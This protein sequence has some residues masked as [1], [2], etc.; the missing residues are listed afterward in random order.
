M[1]NEAG[2][3][4]VPED[5]PRGWRRFL[6]ATNHRDIG[7]MF[8]LFALFA[9]L[10]GGALAYSM[11]AELAAP[12]LTHFSDA[13]DYAVYAT[14]HGLIM[15]FFS[16]LPAAFG[17]AIW[18]VPLM[19]GAPALAFPRIGNLAFWLLPFAFGLF[20]FSFSVP[21]DA[22]GLG[23][24]TGWQMIAPLSSYG[25]PG[26]G[27]DLVMAALFLA[28][29][30]MVLAAITLIATI[31]N[32]RAPG[33]SLRKMPLMAWAGLTA[34]F[35]MLI[36]LP[37]FD[38]GQLM[39]LLDRHFGSTFYNPSGGGDPVIYQHLFWF[40]GHSAGMVGLIIG[41]GMVGHVIPAF[42]G[43]PLLSRL[44]LAYTLIVMALIGL[45]GWGQHLVTTGLSVEAR[46]FFLVAGLAVVVPMGVVVFCLVNTLW[47]G[48]IRL[49]SPM[50]WA[51]GFLPIFTLG[52]LATMVENGG[53]GTLLHGT[54]YEIAAW[55]Y[56]FT[57]PTLF[58][59]F[60]GCYFWFAK[61]SGRRHSELLAKLH[62]WLTL[63][64]AN[65]AFFPMFFLGL[66]GMPRGVADYP[67]AFAGWNRI[68]STGGELL[69]VA[70]I[71][72]PL[73]L[74]LAFVHRRPAGINPW[75]A[76]E[77]LE[78]TLSSP[79]PYQTFDELPKIR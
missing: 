41:I 47:G 56:L 27:V 19:I 38:A 70:Q 51:I 44:S 54:A 52:A 39:L 25:A 77:G 53:A 79:P 16:A 24:A 18:L 50:L 12:G 71:L 3:S 60:A 57:L 11:R 34:A 73:A 17:F 46:A 29:L 14:G 62:F 9:G 32:M 58:A 48:A 1:T 64:G 63:V 37:V 8:L 75:D 26:P 42:S 67:A 20:A 23:V 69:A 31:L 61:F 40:F 59:G 55:H 68:A 33:M 76:A 30:S 35:L 78:W 72:F 10:V 15:L 5:F 6:Y 66:A 28:S 45:M 7:V 65:M 49:T 36:I 22:D 21:G 2:A 43:R 13:R 4:G 74:A